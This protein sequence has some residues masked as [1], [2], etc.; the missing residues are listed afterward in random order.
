MNIYFN[1]EAVVNYGQA[2]VKSRVSD[3][4]TRGGLFAVRWAAVVEALS[5]NFDEASFEYALIG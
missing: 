5:L 3:V 1:A 2:T 4:E